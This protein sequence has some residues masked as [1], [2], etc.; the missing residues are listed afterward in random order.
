LRDGELIA[1]VLLI[2][3]ASLVVALGDSF[4]DRVERS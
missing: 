3:Q 1:E 4:Q 2:Q